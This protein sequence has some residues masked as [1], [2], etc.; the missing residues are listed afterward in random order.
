[1]SSITDLATAR[2]PTTSFTTSTLASPTT[3]MLF[4]ELDAELVLRYPGH[5]AMHFEFSESDVAGGF[6]LVAHTPDTPSGCIALRPLTDLYPTYFPAALRVGEIKRFFTRSSARGTG[7]GKALL[8]EAQR[9]AAEMGFDLLV[10]ET[11][12][13]QVEVLGLYERLGWKRRAL[14]GD[15]DVEAASVEEGGVSMCF[16][17]RIGGE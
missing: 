5:G 2:K 7:V 11:G 4:S 6:I 15:Y 3:Q 17:K 13:K 10:V 8:L 16:E 1:M 12:V 9:R 14:Y